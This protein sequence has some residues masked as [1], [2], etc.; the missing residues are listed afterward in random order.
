MLPA[1][2][3]G[4]RMVALMG[5]LLIITEQYLQPTISNSIS[6]LRELNW[7][8]MIGAHRCFPLAWVLWMVP[9]GDRLAW[10]TVMHTCRSP[11]LLLT[12]CVP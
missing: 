9:V 11:H 2:R 1:R 8:R 6:P 4:L 10:A 12:F 3:Y 7:A 5:L